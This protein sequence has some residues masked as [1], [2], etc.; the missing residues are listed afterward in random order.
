M[1]PTPQSETTLSL[2]GDLFLKNLKEATADMH[3]ALE[4]LPL[5]VSIIDPAVTLTNYQ[6]YLL[7][8]LPIVLDLEQNLYPLLHGLVPNLDQRRKLPLLLQDLETLGVKVP[9]MLPLSLTGSAQHI[10]IPFAMGILYVMEGSTLGGRM[11][12]NNIQK[13]LAFTPVSGAKYF[14]GYGPATGSMWKSFLGDLQ[15]FQVNENAGEEIIRGAQ[16][17]FT[18]IYHHFKG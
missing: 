10:S 5:S 3:Q 13:A 15:T 4:R 16:F 8:M 14:A 11:I 6:D 2:K 7:N 17:A 12:G 9:G 18:T 1:E